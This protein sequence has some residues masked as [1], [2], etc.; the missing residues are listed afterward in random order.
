MRGPARVTHASSFTVE[1]TAGRPS[2][3]H[4]IEFRKL[5]WEAKRLAGTRKRENP[6]EEGLFGIQR[7]RP[8]PRQPELVE[9]RVFDSR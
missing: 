3:G 6:Y 8:R 1:V 2:N 4:L 5:A 7:E 9:G